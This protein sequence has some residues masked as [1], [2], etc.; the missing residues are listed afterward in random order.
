MFYDQE[1]GL[2]RKIGRLTLTHTN[3]VGL[4]HNFMRSTNYSIRQEKA[5]KTF[6]FERVIGSNQPHPDTPVTG[7]MHSFLNMSSFKNLRY[8]YFVHAPNTTG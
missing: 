8:K 6:A 1:N 3:A 5:F 7:N 2:A 4:F